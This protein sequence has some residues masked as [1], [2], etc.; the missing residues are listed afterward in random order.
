MAT[1]PAPPETAAVADALLETLQALATELHRAPPARVLTLDSSLERDFGFDSLGRVELVLRVEQRFGVRLSEHLLA[2]AETPRDVLRAVLAPTAAA[3]LPVSVEAVHAQV[4]TVEG[5]PSGA[6]TLVEVLAWHRDR[7]A[8]RR[9]LFLLDD[10]GCRETLTYG[11]LWAGAIRVARGLRARGVGA[12]QAVA[13]MLPTSRDYFLAFTGILLS[14]GIPVPLYPPL[15]LA[16]IE[17]HLRRQTTILN[18]AQAVLLITVS[19]AQRVGRLLKA[20]VGTLHDVLTVE[21]VSADGD[22]TVPRARGEEIALLQYTSGST[23]VPKGV[24]LTHAN[25]LANIRAMGQA[26]RA[27]SGDVVVSWLPLYHDMGLIGAWLGSLYYAAPLVVMSP[28]T[29]LARPERWLRAIHDYRGTISAGPNFAFELCVRKIDDAALAG[30]DLSSWRL[31]VNGAEPISPDTMTRFIE[32]FSQCGF[33]RGA[34]APVYGLAESSVG[35]AFPPL[36]R[37]PIIDRVAREALAVVGRAEPAAADD[38]TA[39]RFVA[40]GRPLPGHQIRIV[41]DA[42]R[43]V[44]EREVGR[45][46]FVGPSTTSGYYRNADATRALFHGEW[47]DSGDFGYMAEGD[48]YLTGRAKEVII[49]AGRNL[50]PYE[51]EEAV[52]AVPGVRKGCV[53]AFG[54]TDPATGTERLVV[55]AETRETD[56]ARIEALRATIHQLAMDLLHTAP[57]EIVLAP[58]HTVLKT[59]SGKIRR[60]ACRELYERGALGTA[61]RAVW[62]QFARMTLSGLAAR[63]RRVTH[64][65]GRALYAGYAW[66]V[67]GAGI[68]AAWACTLLLPSPAWRRRAVGA[69]ARGFFGLAGIPIRVRRAGEVPGAG[70][71]IFAANHASYLDAVVLSAV[72]PPGGGFVAKRELAGAAIAR[73]FLRRLGAVFVER[74]DP[75]RSAEDARRLVDAVH[76]G[77]SLVVF[78]EGTFG[79]APGLRPFRMG[80]FIVAA[81]TGTPV[82]PVAI[83]GT[84]SILRDGSWFPRRGAISVAIGEPL[85]P[86][87]ADWSAALALRDAARAEILK[88][89]GEPDLEPSAPA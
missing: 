63:S 38:R 49:R 7:H 66:A 14:G 82:V 84:R 25:L 52:G 20:Q 51:L 62:V 24:I 64:D 71:V 61:R 40:C 50:Y 42:G 36:G 58:P 53:A 9:H 19:E 88:S 4:G 47:L 46:E 28:L 86:K 26:V 54:A 2:T 27:H 5:E 55:V 48:V 23:G 10:Q 75:K 78:P 39:L 1:D 83:R 73:V 68:S 3:A 80:A 74:V 33:R 35:L 18:N 87:G 17:D 8:D 37:D 79:R 30:L 32:R 89:C 6:T 57:D 22:E 12:G 41:D 16:Q 43:E 81:E 45:V 15:R 65:L 67:F 60:A 59:S 70:P 13:I 77:R 56:P 69:L 29:F 31:A 44:A 85:R 72:L 21:E 34:M 76:G 11:E